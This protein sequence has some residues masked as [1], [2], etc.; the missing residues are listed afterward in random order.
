MTIEFN[1]DDFESLIEEKGMEEAMNVLAGRMMRAGMKNI[2][3]LAQPYFE[4]QEAQGAERAVGSP[5]SEN[6]QAP[7]S[8]TQVSRLSNFNMEKNGSRVCASTRTYIIRR[9]QAN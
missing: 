8:D 2:D 1:T 6:N 3:E 5:A 7:S 9:G 4:R